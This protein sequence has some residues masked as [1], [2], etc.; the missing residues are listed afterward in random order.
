M[1]MRGH[2]SGIR[3][4]ERIRA[5]GALVVAAVLSLSLSVA[6]APA[7]AA[8]QAAT[9]TS[10]TTTTVPATWDPR[11]QPIADQVASIRGLAFEHPVT[12]VF[13]DDA[14]FE[15]QVV[16]DLRPTRKDEHDLA[17]VGAQLRSL[18]LIGGDVDVRKAVESLASS[19]VAAYYRP[20]TKTITVKGTNLDDVATRVTVAHE[21]T[22]ALQDQHFD[23]DKLQKAAEADNGQT[24]LQA[25]EEGDAVRTADAYEQTLSP[26]EQQ[27]YAAQRAELGRQAIADMKAKGVPDA[28]QVGFGAPYTFGP[29]M[30][31]A[32]VA[33]QQTGAVDAL[34]AAPPTADAVFVTPTN[35]L[36]H[37]TFQTVETPALLPG[38]K[39][40]GK[41]EVL[42]SFSLFHLLSS[43]LD[44]ATALS[45]ADAWDGDSMITFTRKGQTCLRATIAGRAP[46][47]TATI[48]D[49]LNGWAAQMPAGAA[50]IE[51]TADRVTM[52]ACDPG[53]AAAVAPNNAN[54][55]MAFVGNRDGLFST[56]VRNGD[57]VG[58]AMCLG[59]TLVRDP[60]FAPVIEQAGVDPTASPDPATVDAV[61]SRLREIR[62]QCQPT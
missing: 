18:G 53:R 61:R 21:L 49:A 23:L 51:G 37:H 50:T 54:A 34:F 5:A 41:P 29:P 26:D 57:S 14:A 38:E 59:D 27:A 62:A 22:H 3:P 43:R 4:R 17:R 28:L 1:T 12:A 39:R 11:I 30:L 55:S 13:L 16:R 58:A 44:N 25:I 10:S 36:D 33:T 7:A 60:V 19:G 31:D 56:A 40:S 9:T 32:L 52:T 8:K 6:L 2:G 15:A 24:A 45:A 20:K 42:G 48:T 35:L 46:D 47:G